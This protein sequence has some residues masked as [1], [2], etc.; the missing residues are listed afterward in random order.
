MCEGQ[1]AT[2]K[3]QFSS[4]TT[5]DSSDWA[6]NAFTWWI[7][8]LARVNP[9]SLIFNYVC[10]CVDM[11]TRVQVPWESTGVCWIPGSQSLSKASAWT[12]PSLLVKADL[13]GKVRKKWEGSRREYPQHILLTLPTHHSSP[14][15]ILFLANFLDNT[16]IS[17]LTWRWPIILLCF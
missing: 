6:T 10:M 13:V 1:K 4:S 2:C 12:P 8:S 14:I 16:S 7:T 15:S 5:S 9:N 3:S 11:Y 17:Y